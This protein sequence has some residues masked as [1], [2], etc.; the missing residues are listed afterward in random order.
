M[1][2]G[3]LSFVFL[4]G[5][6]FIQSPIFAQTENKVANEF[7]AM[8]DGTEETAQKAIEKFASAEV[9]KNGMIPY[10]KS[11]KVTKVED[12]CVYFTLTDDDEQ[13][14]YFICTSEGKITDF[15]WQE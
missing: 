8:L 11:A 5:F 14:K 10:G 6:L 1:Q 15:D 12:D 3:F 9:I 13:N 4:L 7:L 2:K